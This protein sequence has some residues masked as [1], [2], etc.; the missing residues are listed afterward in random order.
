MWITKA[1]FEDA[2][3]TSV[4]VWFKRRSH[5]RL[6]LVTIFIADSHVFTIPTTWHFTG[7][8][9]PEGHASRD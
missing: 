5:F 8:W 7:A 6:F 4:T 1:H 2:V 3:P 9:L